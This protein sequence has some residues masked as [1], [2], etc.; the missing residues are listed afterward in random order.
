MSL[1]QA[2]YDTLVHPSRAMPQVAESGRF[3]PS[4]AAATA[5]GVLFAAL[6]VPRFD[7]DRAAE[8]AL[9]Q[10]PDAAQMT[11]HQREEAIATARTIGGAAAYA[12]AAFAP[13]L[14]ALGGAVALWLGFKLG[15]GT[16][17]F[18][19]TFAVASCGQLPGAVHQLLLLPAVLKSE[20]LDPSLVPRLLPSSAGAL[21][22]AGASGPGAAFLFSIDLFSAWAV[23]LVIV[24]MAPAARVSHTRAA[25]TT[26]LLWLAWV[27]VFKVALPGLGGNR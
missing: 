12:G 7:F 1:A 5:A 22:P 23:A 3:L 10:K 21:L 27:A 4:L 16:P 8:K 24:G 13:A 6:A 18:R 14:L 17:A 20:A 15:G 11:P 9:D 19:P 26:I 2:L 25:V